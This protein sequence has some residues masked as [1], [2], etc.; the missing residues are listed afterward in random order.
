MD[1]DTLLPLFLYKES[2]EPTNMFETEI[3]CPFVAVLLIF[4]SVSWTLCCLYF[5]PAG[6]QQSTPVGCGRRSGTRQYCAHLVCTLLVCVR[7]AKKSQ[8]YHE[9]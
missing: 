9:V 8:D 4:G 3:P 7:I 2:K 6:K 1:A 5:G